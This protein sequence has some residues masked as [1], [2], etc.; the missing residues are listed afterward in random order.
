MWDDEGVLMKGTV[1][2][3]PEFNSTTSEIATK[4]PVIQVSSASPCHPDALAFSAK[5]LVIF[6]PKKY[7]VGDHW[8][9][10][11][12]SSSEIISA[13]TKQVS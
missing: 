11:T 3:S 8:N 1:Q 2:W 12:Q 13:K 6:A 4:D 9:H 7:L 5:K 10:V